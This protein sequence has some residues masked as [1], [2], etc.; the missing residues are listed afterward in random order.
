MIETVIRETEQV[1]LTSPIRFPRR[2]T[3]PNQIKILK[4]VIFFFSLQF[5][6][7]FKASYLCLVQY[8]LGKTPNLHGFTVLTHKNDGYVLYFTAIYTRQNPNNHSFIVTINLHQANSSV[9][10]FGS[11]NCKFQTLCHDLFLQFLAFLSNTAYQHD[12][13]FYECTILE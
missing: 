10:F 11:I 12:T 2:F 3:F 7:H 4:F 5:M 13:W 6:R 8:H 1:I 9:P